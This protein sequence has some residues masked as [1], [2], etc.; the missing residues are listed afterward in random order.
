MRLIVRRDPSFF[1]EPDHIRRRQ[2][3]VAAGDG[4]RSG[5]RLRNDHRIRIDDLFTLRGNANV[6]PKTKSEYIDTGKVRYVFREFPLDIKAAVASMLARC[7]AEDD[8]G[9][10]FAV[11]DMLFKTR[12]EWVVKTGET[13]NRIGKEAGMSEQSVETV[14]APTMPMSVCDGAEPL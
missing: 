12:D 7:I 9:K 3:S 2:A 5:Q 1:R 13:L 6:F 11:I 14:V 8:A 10:Y 4:A